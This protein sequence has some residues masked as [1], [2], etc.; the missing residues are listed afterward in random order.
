MLL[1]A[2]WVGISGVLSKVTIL[3]TLIR[4]LITPLV[5]THEP[6]SIDSEFC[7]GCGLTAHTSRPV[8]ASF[9]P[10]EG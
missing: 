3:L 8:V 4:G 1:G 9:R 7:G 5:T 2:S 6:P 10:V